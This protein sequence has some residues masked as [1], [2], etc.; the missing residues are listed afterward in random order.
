MR[1]SWLY[2]RDGSRPLTGAMNANNQNINAINTA[3]GQRFAAT[4]NMQA[5]KF[6]DS[7]NIEFKGDFSGTSTMNRINAQ[8]LKLTGNAV[9]GDSCATRDVATT[10]SGALLSCVNGQWTIPGTAGAMLFG[11]TFVEESYGGSA[12][13][14]HTPNLVTNAC[15]C[16]DGYNAVVASKGGWYGGKPWSSF[17]HGYSCQKTI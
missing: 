14:C 12:T 6:I 10:A 2:P 4:I 3:T 13:T 16:P 8:I 11:G 5:P 17:Y 1:Q 9:E 15:S 7:K